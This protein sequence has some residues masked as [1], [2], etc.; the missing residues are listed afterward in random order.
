MRFITSGFRAF[1]ASF[2][3]VL[4]VAAAAADDSTWTSQQDRCSISLPNA[5]WTERKPP[6]PDVKWLAVNHAKTKMISVAVFSYPQ[7]TTELSRSGFDEGYLKSV[8]GTKIKGGDFA[9]DGRMAYRVVAESTLSGKN[10]SNVAVAVI[11]HGRAYRNDAQTSAGDADTDPEINASINSFHVLDSLDPPAPANRAPA[12]GE[13]LAY[14]IGEFVGGCFALLLIG[15]PLVYLGKKF[16]VRAGREGRSSDPP[17]SRV[18]AP[19]R[20]QPAQLLSAEQAEFFATVVKNRLAAGDTAGAAQFY[21][22]Q[23]ESHPDWKLGETNLMTLI[24]SLHQ[25]QLWSASFRPMVDYARQFPE[26]SVRVQFKL[27]QL[28]IDVAHRPAKALQVL[29]G[30]DVP[31]LVPDL[32]MLHDKLR[33]AAEKLQTEGDLEVAGEDDW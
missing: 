31:K 29:R 9:I 25:Q 30:I 33:V 12:T 15:V 13:E 7:G 6:M 17:I 28:L 5:S 20:P 21:Q 10:I 23:R 16:V 24:K 22:Q 27:A 1:S 14:R 32:R 18:T 2:V 11:S 3:W 26:T 19:T 8:S 4:F